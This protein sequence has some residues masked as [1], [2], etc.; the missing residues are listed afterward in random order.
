MGKKKNKDTPEN[1]TASLVVAAGAA[2]YFGTT[3]QPKRVKFASKVKGSVYLQCMRANP[4]LTKE[5]LKAKI[6]SEAEAAINALVG[7]NIKVIRSE[8]DKEPLNGLSGSK[9]TRTSVQIGNY[10]FSIDDSQTVPDT[11]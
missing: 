8:G 2:K 9:E 3:P 11:T 4:D 5:E 6:I 10:T 1:V 7:P